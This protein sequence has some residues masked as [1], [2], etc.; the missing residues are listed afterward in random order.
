MARKVARKRR[1]D[2]PRGPERY[3][4]WHDAAAWRLKT[5][6]TRRRMLEMSAE[7]FYDWVRGHRD[8]F[9]AF[10]YAYKWPE[11]MVILGY[12]R[13]GVEASRGAWLRE[14][15]IHNWPS[16]LLTPDELQQA[17]SSPIDLCSSVP[18]KFCGVLK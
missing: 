18:C 14:D 11:G 2:H 17:L 13:E 8:D 12:T 10:C 1:A 7:A 4:H 5:T 16:S 15:L 3:P 6:M 9:T